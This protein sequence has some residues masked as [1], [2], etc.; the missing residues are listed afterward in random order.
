MTDE[1]IAGFFPQHEVH[2]GRD[3]GGR[4]AT[5]TPDDVAHYEA[6]I[7]GPTPRLTLASG[8]VAAPALLFHS[9]VYRS[10]AWYLPNIFGNL[11]ARQEWQLFAPLT[12][13]ATVRTRSTVVERYVKRNREYVVNEVLVTDDAGRW[14]QRSRT[15]QSFLVADERR[16]LVVDREREKRVDRQFAI[17]EGDG[18][19]LTPLSRTITLAMCEAFSGPEKN[20]HTDREAARMLGFP[21]VV[22]QGMWSICLVSEL[23][24]AAYGLAW[25]VGGSLDLRLVNVIWAEDAVTA[26]G[27]VREE[28]PEGG[29]RRVYVDV[30]CEKADGTKAT[31]GTASVLQ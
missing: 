11:H 14:L 10:L 12:V 26:H 3:L 13:G 16:G 21:D 30:W 29:K 7:G 2:V 17:G 6:G 18:V 24:T 22:V 31:V 20:Y 9:E 15:H 27:K 23:M 19:A 5:I 8:A 4:A 1:A 25:H 28:I